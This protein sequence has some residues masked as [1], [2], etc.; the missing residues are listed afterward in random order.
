MSNRPLLL[1]TAVRKIISPVLRECPRE[2]GVVTIT[3]VDVSPDLSF[4][5]V[6]VSSLLQPKAAIAFLDGRQ[7]ELQKRMGTLQTHK[8]PK[9]RFRIDKTAEEGTRID[10]L[11]K[12][13]AGSTPEESSES[14]Q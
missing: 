9:L 12:R 14:S 3:D 2:C 8:T 7:R 5:T 1:A 10:Q 6:Y 13:A 11:L 4:A